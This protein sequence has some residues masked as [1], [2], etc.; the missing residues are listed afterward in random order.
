MTSAVAMSQPSH[1]ELFAGS[2]LTADG[3]KGSGLR[4]DQMVRKLST[5]W[6]YF[7]EVQNNHDLVDSVLNVMLLLHVYSQAEFSTWKYFDGYIFSIPSRR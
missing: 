3:N 6:H 7:H 1:G 5:V 2:S 4:A